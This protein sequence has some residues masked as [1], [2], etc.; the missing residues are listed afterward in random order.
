METMGFFSASLAADCTYCHVPESGGSWER[1]ADDNAHKRT[2]RRMMLMVSA[3]NRDNFGG[4]QVVTCYTCHRGGNRPKV[5]PSLAA[6]YGASTLEENDDVIAAAPGA[7]SA[8]QILDKYIRALG[9]AERLAGLTSVVAKGTYEAYTDRVKHPVEIF[10]KAPAQRATIV[11]APDGDISTI[12]DG[13]AGWL[14]A[15]AS[16]RPVRVLALTGGDLDAARLEAEM[17]VI[18]RRPSSTRLRSAG[19]SAVGS[20][21]GS[22]ASASCSCRRSRWARGPWICRA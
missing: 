13:R 18:S 9:G 20:S 11:H 12:Y 16:E 22:F 6:L 10:A 3:I 7:A 14:A 1:Y 4:R 19:H 21:V 8:D 15:P 17:L 5:T 2:A